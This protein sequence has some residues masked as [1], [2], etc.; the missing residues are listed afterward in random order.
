M[1]NGLLSALLVSVVLFFYRHPPLAP[2]PS[3]HRSVL[4]HL[5]LRKWNN[6][7]CDILRL[8]FF[9]QHRGLESY[10]R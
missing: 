2:N 7:V 5:S 3:N 10:P 6:A 4:H 9:I 8:A 1:Q